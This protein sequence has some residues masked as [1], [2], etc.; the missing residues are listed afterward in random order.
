MGPGHSSGDA[1]PGE[2]CF[3][4]R[5]DRKI[6]AVIR[7]EQ[8]G[9]QSFLGVSFP[10]PVGGTTKGQGQGRWSWEEGCY[11]EVGIHLPAPSSAH[12]CRVTRLR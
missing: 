11:P 2:G 5:P 8:F 10:I 6:L 1:C 9:E 12:R 7:E 4:Q 3:L